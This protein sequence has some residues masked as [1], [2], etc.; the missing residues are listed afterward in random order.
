MLL[1]GAFGHLV[2]GATPG[3]CTDAK[4]F[5]WSFRNGLVIRDN[6]VFGNGRVGISF[7]GG[8]DG[9]TIG[10]GTQVISN[11]VEHEKSGIFYG[12]SPSHS[13]HGSDTNENR[14]YDQSGSENNVTLNTGHIYRQQLYNQKYETVDG[15]GILVQC[16]NG[17]NQYRN[18]WDRNDLSG[19]GSGY[20]A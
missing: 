6:Y 12:F 13:P 7:S 1:G 19:G 20:I 4:M 17:N 9:K 18:L 3:H 11:H 8:G 14:G 2:P 16:T 15:E 5:P 10:S